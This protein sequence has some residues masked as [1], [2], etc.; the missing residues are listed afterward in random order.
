MSA[1]RY[2]PNQ[3]YLHCDD[4]LMPKRRNVWSAWNYLTERQL[5]QD[6]TMTVSYWMNLLQNLDNDKPV[7]VTLNPAV[8]PAAEKTFGHFVYD[9]P[10][11]D[12]AALRAQES[13]DTI[14]GMNGV[15]FCGA[16]TGYGFHEDGLQ[17]AI[18]VCEGLE[19]ASGRVREAAE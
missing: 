18:R 5:A 13:L 4:R 17:S 15:W 7:F 3:V 11:F 6:G 12:Q 14:Q 9:H 1:V 16:W 10:Q 2:L 19:A 8:P